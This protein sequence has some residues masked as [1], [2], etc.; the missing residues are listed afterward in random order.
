MKVGNAFLDFGR[1]LDR[2]CESYT[3]EL[4]VT[5]ES[6]AAAR[7]DLVRRTIGAEEMLFIVFV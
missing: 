3:E 2:L 1:E 5:Y 7:G 4:G 6:G